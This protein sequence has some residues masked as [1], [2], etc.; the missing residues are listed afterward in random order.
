MRTLFLLA[1]FLFTG[2][3]A[4][5]QFPLGHTTVTFN[6]PTRSGGF[7]TGGG[8]GRQIQTEIY[9]PAASDGDNTPAAEGQFPVVIFGHGFVMGWDVYDNVWETLVSKGYI[10][11][12]PRTEGGLAPNHGDFGLDIALL[13]SKMQGLNT[14]ASSVLFGRIAE[15][16]ALGGHSMGGGASVL[17][18]NTPGVS[19]H[20]ALAPAET[21]PSAIGAAAQVAVPSMIFSGGADGVTPPS[22]HQIPIYNALD[23]E[24]KYHITITGGGHCFFANASTTCDL[25]EFI[26]SGG[27]TITREEQHQRTFE[28]LVPWLEFWLKG[29]AFAMD[30]INFLLGIGT[31]VTHESSCSNPVGLTEFESGSAVLFPNPFSGN[32]TLRHHMPL[33]LD[34]SVSNAL[35]QLVYSGKILFAEQEINFEFASPGVYAVQLTDVNGKSELLRLIRQ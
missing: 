11:A 19:A 33:P 31:G 29:Q 20:F 14:L 24:C 5:A 18:A 32:P 21:D 25:G 22:D 35:G 30:D 34:Y 9:Y 13:V 28:Y 26:T 12:L 6:D 4:F 3:F 1:L 17:A 27:I 8:P 23:S 2:M 10:V 16:T 15:P 7:G